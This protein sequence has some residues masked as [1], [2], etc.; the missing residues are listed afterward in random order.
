[1]NPDHQ[2]LSLILDVWYVDGPPLFINPWQS[3]VDHQLLMIKCWW[4]WTIKSWH[5][6]KLDG[7]LLLASSR[8]FTV[9]NQLFMVKCWWIKKNHQELMD[10]MYTIFG[11]IL[12]VYSWPLTIDWC[13][14]S[15]VD[16][17]NL[18]VLYVDGPLL[19][20]SS[21]QSTADNQLLMNLDYQELMIQNFMVHYY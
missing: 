20:V 15:S 14:P 19:L 9:D 16:S 8:Q 10:K 11:R 1:M 5:N 18:D 17:S 4:I 21:W 7:P 3:T 13:E 6:P 2:E 12:A